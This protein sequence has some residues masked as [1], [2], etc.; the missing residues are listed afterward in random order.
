METARHDPVGRTIQA[1]QSELPRTL[2][3]SGHKCCYPIPGRGTECTEGSAAGSAPANPES[4]PSMRLIGLG[5]GVINHHPKGRAV[6]GRQ[7]APHEGRF[8]TKAKE[9]HSVERQ[10]CY[11]A[12]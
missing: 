1:E 7:R 5:R 2:R 6:W 10:Q 4:P 9:T 8:I 11:G 3:I 12:D